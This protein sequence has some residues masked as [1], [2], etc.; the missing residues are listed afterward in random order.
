RDRLLLRPDDPGLVHALDRP[1]Q[2]LHAE[3]DPDRRVSLHAPSLHRLQ[4]GAADPSAADGVIP[5]SGGV[6]LCDQAAQACLDRES[7]LLAGQ[8]RG[9]PA[10]L[11]DE[12]QRRQ[13]HEAELAR[14]A[15]A[16]IDDAWITDVITAHE[17]ARGTACVLDVDT[18]ETDFAP[19]PT[20]EG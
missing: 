14:Q 4:Q 7:R 17:G 15:G 20:V 19:V 12:K 13:A 6:A 2:R 11:V 16:L 1:A 9:D 10:V 3:A 5:R 8:H 18:E